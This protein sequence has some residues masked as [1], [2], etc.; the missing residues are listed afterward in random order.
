MRGFG[1]GPIKPKAIDE[2]PEKFDIKA[3]LLKIREQTEVKI[4]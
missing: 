3:E 4:K 2:K 1:V